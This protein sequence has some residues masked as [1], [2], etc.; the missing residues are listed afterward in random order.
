MTMEETEKE[1]MEEE[2]VV[3]EEEEGA[4]VTEKIERVARHPDFRGTSGYLSFGNRLPE[5]T[6][7]HLLGEDRES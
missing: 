3:V 1:V 6:Q 7:E 5:K 4:T 2:E